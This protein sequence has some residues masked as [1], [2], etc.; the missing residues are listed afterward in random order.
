MSKFSS[1][2]RAVHTFVV[3]NF[4]CQE[5][6]YIIYPFG[7]IYKLLGFAPIQLR[8]GEVLRNGCDRIF[9][10]DTKA[11]IC[12]CLNIMIY[13]MGFC[14][15]ILR[16]RAVPYKHGDGISRLTS[17]AQVF[18]LF[19]LGLIAWVTAWTH[20]D[21]QCR[22]HA[23]I[24]RIDQHLREI[25][26]IQF[27]Y[28]SLRRRLFWQLGLQLL[29]AFP[30]SMVNCIIILPDE[31]PF[32]PFSTCYIFICFMPISVLIFKQFQFYNLMHVLKTKLDLINNKLSKF[33][34]NTRFTSERR[35]IVTV[36]KSNSVSEVPL[37]ALLTIY[38]N[39]SDGIDLVLRIFGWHLL[40]LTAVSFGVITV[41]SYNLFS[42]ISHSLV[43]P[44]YHVVFIVSWILVQVMAFAVNILICGKTSRMMET[45]I[46]ILHKIRLSSNE[47]PDACVFYQILQIFSMEVLQRKRNF[48]AAGF[49]DMD[50][51]LITSIIASATT[52]LVIII[53]F[54]L[55]NIPDCHFPK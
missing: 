51:K 48:N 29:I 55:T 3:G 31:M 26:D 5:F 34:R 44:T 15:G 11:W 45:T 9:Q 43:I 19:G 46:S 27:D 28:K 10:W 20:M 37:T 4:H 47:A 42:L 32:S 24:T 38:S 6:A 23:L 52:Y 39:V 54:H 30:L 21:E 53:Q 8:R 7:R 13:T 35:H 41:Q 33:N 12:S 1:C 17:W 2:L 22:L 16:L 36:R 40:F 25:D 14:L 18:T 49:F 50:Y